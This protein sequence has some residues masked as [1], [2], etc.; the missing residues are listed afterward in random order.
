MAEIINLNRYR[1]EAASKAQ[2]AQAEV[3]RL[4]FGR[5]KQDKQASQKAKSDIERLLDGHLL[6]P[7]D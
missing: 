3:N 2:K 7:K 4:T 1:K 6:T 5:S